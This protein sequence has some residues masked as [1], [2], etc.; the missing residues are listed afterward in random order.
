MS[1][2]SIFEPNDECDAAQVGREWIPEKDKEDL[3]V[4]VGVVV[5]VD[6]EEVRKV[7][8]GEIVQRPWRE[9]TIECV[10]YVGDTEPVELQQDGCDVVSK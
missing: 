5:V 3:T 4:R 8:R 2:K 10:G 7:W 1:F 9:A 6:V